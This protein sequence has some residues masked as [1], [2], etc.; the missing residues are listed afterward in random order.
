[1]IN[2]RV[3]LFLLLFVALPACVRRDGRN[4]DC[5]W[6]GEIGS[7]RLTANQPGFREHIIG[8]LEFAEDLAIRY[9]DS[10]RGLREAQTAADAKNGCMGNLLNEIGAV[11]GITAEEAFQYFGQRRLG[12]DL[13]MALPFFLLCGFAADVMVRRVRGRHPRE[14]GLAAVA[15][16]VVCSLV[17]ALGGLLIGG[18]WSSSAESL[19]IGT[20]HLSNRALRLPWEQHRAEIFVLLTILFWVIAAV[21]YRVRGKALA[22][23]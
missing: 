2:Q 15:V 22:A 23:E 21:R 1:M 14:E 9:M 6:P 17:F 16:I 13:A 8:D 4:A 18:F 3:S 20:G 7:T 12:V 19:R 11:H 10:R 5:Q